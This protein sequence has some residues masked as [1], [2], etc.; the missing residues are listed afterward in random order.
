MKKIVKVMKVLIFET[1]V[2]VDD[3][4]PVAS[5]RCVA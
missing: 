1:V 5:Y 4:I 2:K 3:E